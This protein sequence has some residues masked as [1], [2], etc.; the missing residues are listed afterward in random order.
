ML[1]VSSSMSSERNKTLARHNDGWLSPLE[2]RA[3]GWLSP[4][5]PAWLSP[6]GLTAV[7]FA[8]SVAAFC[9]YALAAGQPA[10]LW[11]VNAGL[12]VNW[13]GDSLD[14]SVARSR[15]IERPRFGFFLDQSTDVLGQFLF[16]MGLALSGYVPI[17]IAVTGLAVYL[18]MSVLGLLRA[19]VS[20][21]FHLAT[22]GFGLTELRCLLIVANILFYFVPPHPFRIGGIDTT[23]AEL[24]GLAWIVVTL[25]LYLATM[26]G[27]A[28]QLAREEPLPTRS[29]HEP[30]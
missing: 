25:G 21:V 20:R 7:G 24:L 4:R 12:V 3:L 27:E 1:Q 16:A 17:G 19:E 22:G 5:V 11:F 28:R 8:G 18:M 29:R 14:G 9:G 23:Y 26:I 10:W 2:K 6:N 15:R 30:K 13:L